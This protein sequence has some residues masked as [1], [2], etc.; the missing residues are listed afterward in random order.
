MTVNLNKHTHISNYQKA[1]VSIFDKKKTWEY[2][3]DGRRIALNKKIALK[4]KK[5]LLTSSLL[6]DIDDVIYH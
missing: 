4:K 6:A 2:L 1:L 3:K 5:K